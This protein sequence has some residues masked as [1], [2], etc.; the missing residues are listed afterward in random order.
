MFAPTQT[1]PTIGIL[2]DAGVLGKLAFNGA[3]TLTVDATGTAALISASTWTPTIAGSTT[4]GSH[5]YT[6][7][8]GQYIKIATL[9]VATFN[10]VLNAKDAAM[11]GNVTITGLPFTVKNN[12]NAHWGHSMWTWSGLATA[13]ISAP[14][15]AS[16]NSTLMNVFKTTAATTALGS[17]VAADLQ[18][19]SQL[20]GTIAYESAS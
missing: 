1:V 8:V 14:L 5:T 17:M 15:F 20:A 16:V 4:A 11:A 12:T 19:G 7:R 10:I 2:D 13:I 6:V 18:N 3:F 9:V